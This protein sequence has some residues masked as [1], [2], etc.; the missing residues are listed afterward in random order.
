M[1]SF[2]QS[3][4]SKKKEHE[5]NSDSYSDEISENRKK[6]LLKVND[7]VISRDS[8]LSNIEKNKTTQS[9]I[10]DNKLKNKLTE[11]DKDSPE[12]QV[13]LK[14]LNQIS[15][16]EKLVDTINQ[17]FESNKIEKISLDNDDLNVPTVKVKFKDIEYKKSFDESN[18]DKNINSI[19]NYLDELDYNKG[20][21]QFINEKKENITKNLDENV[22]SERFISGYID[23]ESDFNQQMKEY[24]KDLLKPLKYDL[25]AITEEVEFTDDLKESIWITPDNK[26]I[27]GEYD[28][29]KRGTDHNSLL[30]IYGL[31]R[32]DNSSWDKIHQMGF[33]RMVSETDTALVYKNQPFSK[34]QKEI[35]EK[36]GFSIVDY[37]TLEKVKSHEN[38]KNKVSK[39]QEDEKLER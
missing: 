20:K 10:N 2:L 39:R 13:A 38:D 22:H 15:R 30:D 23:A 36:G 16:V 25:K 3:I 19:K 18:I 33:V 11:L 29:D 37:G 31:D 28:S 6:G 14:Y 8:T 17:N 7:L 1:A 9:G 27:W 12:Y 24:S 35:I 5:N 26:M 34:E 21:L 4:F 32:N